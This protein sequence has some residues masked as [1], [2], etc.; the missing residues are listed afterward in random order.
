MWD[1][2]NIFNKIPH[3][4]TGIFE[5]AE[6]KILII[7][8]E[9]DVSIDFL[10]V[11]E[12][13]SNKEL[14]HRAVLGSILGTGVKREVIGD[15][16]INN[17]IANVVILKEISKYLLQNIDKIGRENVKVKRIDFNQTVS[18]APNFKEIK[19]TVASLRLDAVVAV[20]YGLSREVSSKLI[21]NDKVSLNYKE[22]ANSSKIVKIGDLISVRGYGRFE[23]QDV[24]GETRKDRVRV[25]LKVYGK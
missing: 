5:E 8:T 23:I 4:L 3:Y 7:G 14:K 9:E 25:V 15:I 2:S 24:L 11:L 10:E 18:V 17:N 12:I 20:C 22:I 16:A 1:N 21:E 6:R 19:T 13:T